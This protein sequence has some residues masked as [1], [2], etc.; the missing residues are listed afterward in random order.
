MQARDRRL[1]AAHPPGTLIAT[2]DLPVHASA[3]HSALGRASPVA[4]KCS[5]QRVRLPRSGFGPSRAP[6]ESIPCSTTRA[7]GRGSNA[8]LSINVPLIASNCL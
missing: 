4:C 8:R 3:H 7:S 1:E 6:G 5:P 2:D